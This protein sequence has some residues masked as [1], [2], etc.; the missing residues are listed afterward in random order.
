MKL[1]WKP[2][3]TTNGVIKCYSVQC[4]DIVINEFGEI[5][6]DTITGKIRALSPETKYTLHL[7]AHTRVGEG[8][9][10]SR[11]FKTSKLCNKTAI[12]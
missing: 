7:K 8:P 1:Q 10:A 4:G 11:S 9:P 3:Q 12:V 5:T 2:P 6:S